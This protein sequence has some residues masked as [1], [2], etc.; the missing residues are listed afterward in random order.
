MNNQKFFNDIKNKIFQKNFFGIFNMELKNN[1]VM[2]S[3]QPY[4]DSFGY[5][6]QKID[7]NFRD[8]KLE[9]EKYAINFY[10]LDKYMNKI[11]DFLKKN[12]E[13]I[14]KFGFTL[15]KLALI[16]KEDIIKSF[17]F[18]NIKTL[19]E[20]RFDDLSSITIK[21]EFQE[22]ENKDGFLIIIW[23]LDFDSLYNEDQ[24]PKM[25]KKEIV[26]DRI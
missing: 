19:D 21:I 12:E 26:V 5:I 17:F 25:F 16:P 23:E 3:Y 6:K 13:F 14:N 1:I 15:D 7:L 8:F 10:R 9:L 18:D 4:V 11:F 24:K 20:I 2:L 22:L